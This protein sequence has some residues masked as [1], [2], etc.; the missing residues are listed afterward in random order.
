MDDNLNFSFTIEKIASER[1]VFRANA[2]FFVLEA[3]ELA[4]VSHVG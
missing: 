1:G 2:Y 4:V 3:I